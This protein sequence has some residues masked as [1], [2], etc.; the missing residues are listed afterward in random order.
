MPGLFKLLGRRAKRGCEPRFGRYRIIRASK[1]RD[2]FLTLSRVGT[3]FNTQAPAAG[4]DSAAV[5]ILA[6]GAR[7][8]LGL[9]RLDL[10]RTLCDLALSEDERNAD[11]QSLAANILD[12]Q[13]DWQ[14]SLACLRRAYALAP[15]A[16]QVRL[17][18][19]MALLRCGDYREGFALYEARVDK[20]GWS[21]F[22]TSESRAALRHRMLRP[23]QSVEGKGILVLAEQ[24]LGD[25]IMFARY[26][27]RLIAR[28]ARVA[29]ACNPT[30][31]PMFERVAGIEKVLAPP[32]DQPLAQINLAALSLDAWTP[33]LSLAFWFETDVESVPAETPYWTPDAERVAYWHR[34]LAGMGRAGA[35]K[36]GLVFQANPGGA[37]FAEKSMTVDEVLPLA[38]LEGIDIVNLQHGAAGR[39]LVKAVPGMI[40]P[41]PTPVALD[42]YAAAI[43][44]TDLLI[45]VDTMAAHCAGAMGRPTWLAVPQSPHWAW[46]LDGETTP[47]YRLIRIFRQAKRRDWSNVVATLLAQLQ[48]R[49]PAANA[50][51]PHIQIPHIPSLQALVTAELPATA[52]R[53]EP[54]GEHRVDDRQAAQALA[55]VAQALKACGRDDLARTVAAL[56]ARLDDA[57]ENSR[58]IRDAMGDALE[59]NDRKAVP[60]KRRQTAAGDTAEVRFELA[61]AQ[62]LLG[63]LEQGFANYE[64][65]RELPLWLEQ[66]LPIP[67]S[68]AALASRALNPGDPVD[69][70]RIVV[71]TEQGLGD[72]FFGARFLSVLAQ[73]GARITLVCRAPMR[74]FFARL[75]CLDA[76]LSPPQDQPSAKI[77]LGRL[78]FDV[79]CPLLSLPFV[80]GIAS[81]DDARKP[82]YLGV[83]PA[84]AA[85]WRARYGREGR[86]GPRK[87]GLVWRANPANRML[88]GRSLDLADLAP[89]AGLDD[90]DWVNLQ[91]GD[92]ARGLLAAL[93]NLIDVTREPLPL[94]E[95]AAAVAATDLVVSVDTMAAHCAGALGHPSPEGKPQVCS[96]LAFS[97]HSLS[98]AARCCSQVP[99]RTATR[100]SG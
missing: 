48:A 97:H 2:V 98:S 51:G 7:Q 18:L 56:F 88:S 72:T 17:N 32:A 26:I 78:A 47:W 96:L 75:A 76:I 69:G 77:N 59:Q 92:A 58:Y 82:P 12:R 28:G 6:N 24:G 41:F 95:F 50:P 74:P 100:I 86:P 9:E 42:E 61:R 4:A 85:A 10:A 25:G 55:G 33:L 71:F 84:Q 68:L 49:F 52:Q 15:Q 73:R 67:G 87:I 23:G 43:A 19:A 30:L 20:P 40:D 27:A 8:F 13:S 65:R 37:A 46:G 79:F 14:S 21:A 36:A 29:V 57:G 62:L 45:S 5:L 34:R 94:D 3:E 80:L 1:H 81:S 93:P 53:H 22:A 31:R 70:R 44:A 99:T 64:A 11:I 54:A 89:L 60:E 83:D 66:A 16:P 63:D 39:D 38:A 35:A 90:V 91:D